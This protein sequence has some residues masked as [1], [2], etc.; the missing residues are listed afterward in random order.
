MKLLMYAQILW[1]IHKLGRVTKP[2]L[3]QAYTILFWICEKSIKVEN[4]YLFKVL[5]ETNHCFIW[6]IAICFIMLL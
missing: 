2:L 5:T 3:W 4:S 1:P 6:A